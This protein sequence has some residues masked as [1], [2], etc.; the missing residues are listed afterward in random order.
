MKRTCEAFTLIELLVVISIIALL[1]AILLPALGKARESARL[2]GCLSNQRQHLVAINCYV[3]D[4]NNYLPCSK[5]YNGSGSPITLPVVWKM[6]I[7][8]YM[9]VP[10]HNNGSASQMP[11]ADTQVNH[12]IAEGVFA[13]PE[14]RQ[15]IATA[16][17]KYGEGGYGWNLYYMGA[18]DYINGNPGS[19]SNRRVKMDEVIRPSDTITHADD[20]DFPNQPWDGNGM[21]EMLCANKPSKI[22]ITV[23][24][25]GGTFHTITI[26]GKRHLDSGQAT[27]FVDGHAAMMSFQTLST[28][29]GG[30]IDYYYRRDKFN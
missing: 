9:N 6:E 24:D 7:A 4:Q 12:K 10:I 8:R 22:T 23:K 11:T 5:S 29:K 27:S 18:F 20:I 2:A 25:G 30:D 13:C 3:N 26:P 16:K 19:D 1:I 21:G 28:G 15:T 14:S 17:F